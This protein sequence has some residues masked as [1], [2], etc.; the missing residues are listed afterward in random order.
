MDDLS[1]RR[2]AAQ[3][4]R[5]ARIDPFVSSGGPTNLSSNSDAAVR[6]G[7][8]PSRRQCSLSSDGRVSVWKSGGVGD[9]VE[10]SRLAEL[11]IA[12]SLATDPLP[13]NAS[14]VPGEVLDS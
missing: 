7:G 2:R 3:C 11:T 8:V 9:E 6:R 5:S 14:R 10:V 12:L 13:A 4:S 1:A